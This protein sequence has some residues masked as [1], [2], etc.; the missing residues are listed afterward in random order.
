MSGKIQVYGDDDT[1]RADL[2]YV[3][4]V[5]NQPVLS[6]EKEQELAYAWRDHGNESALHEL[7]KAYSRLVVSSAIKFRHYG[8]PISDLIQEGNVGLMQ[9]AERFD[10]ERD[11]RF[12]TYAK[13]WIRSFIQDYILRNW[14]IVRT[15]STSAQKQ[16][17][18]NLRR[19]RSQLASVTT[20]SIGPEDRQKI[21]DILRVS[22]RDVE[23]MENRLSG[24]DLSLSSSLGDESNED[25]VDTLVDQNP[26]PETEALE[27]YDRLVRR[28]WLESSLRQLPIRER[29]IVQCRHLSESPL[30][31]EQIGD[32]MNISKERVRQLETRA[33]RKMKHHLAKNIR[34]VKEVLW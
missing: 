28:H 1:Q 5:M 4:E 23:N 34:D 27:E 14:S 9:A 12:S 2:A 33:L 13:W 21:A 24:H 25:W 26:S 32:M 6:R 29:Q 11:I 19:L 30:T 31:L 17:F 20:D 7:T 18:F 10:P 3:R 8:L 15:G 22:I 16:L